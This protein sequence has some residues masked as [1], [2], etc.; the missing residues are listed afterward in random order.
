M[1]HSPRIGSMSFL[2]RNRIHRRVGVALL[3]MLVASI[4]AVA[5]DFQLF[6]LTIVLVYAI[7]LLGVNILTG[8]NGQISLGHGAFYTLGA[9]TTAIL[10]TFAAV[11]HWIAL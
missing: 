6:K 2:L 10:V 3:L 8:Y 7:A 11:P 4:A 5:T 9:Y 1:S